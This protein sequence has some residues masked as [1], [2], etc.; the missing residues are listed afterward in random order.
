[1]HPRSRQG[2][3]PPRAPASE[4]TDRSIDRPKR[5][6]HGVVRNPTR[7]VSNQRAVV[8]VTD[9][10]LIHPPLDTTPIH[11][12]PQP[13]KAS[14]PAMY[15]R[16]AA[17]Q[18]LRRLATTI[19]TTGRNHSSAAPCSSALLRPPPQQ[20]Q[21]HHHPALLLS[22]FPQQQPRRAFVAT[23]GGPPRPPPPPPQSPVGAAGGGG[24]GAQQKPQ[25]ASTAGG[26]SVIELNDKVRGIE[27]RAIRG[28]GRK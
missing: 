11:P 1:M 24:G 26:A 16:P 15:A 2:G 8:F 19:I 25:P 21:R 6:R 18:Q 28:W 5:A 12:H 13:A 27:N 7:L 4:S 9:D 14:Q 22:T 20:W 23:A 3:R 10:S 17:R